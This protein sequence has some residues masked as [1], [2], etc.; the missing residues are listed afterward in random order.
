[1]TLFRQRRR[2]IGATQDDSNVFTT[3]GH[4]TGGGGGG[5]AGAIGLYGGNGGYGGNGYGG[6]GGY[7]GKGLTPG[8]TSSA[9]LTL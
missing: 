8:R 5:G 4:G 9:G 6:Y 3:G 1:M 2:G 7:G